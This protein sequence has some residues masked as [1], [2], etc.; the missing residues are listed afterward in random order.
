[1]EKKKVS[2]EKLL[3]SFDDKKK[4]KNKEKSKEKNKKPSFKRKEL[5]EDERKTIY[6][7]SRVLTKG[8]VDSLIFST[9][10]RSCFSSISYLD[11]FAD[12]MTR[13][14]VHRIIFEMNKHKQPGESDIFLCFSRRESSDADFKISRTRKGEEGDTHPINKTSGERI[15]MTFMGKDDSHVVSFEK[16]ETEDNLVLK[17]LPTSCFSV[18]NEKLIVRFQTPFGPKDIAPHYSFVKKMKKKEIFK[19]IPKE[20]F[21]QLVERRS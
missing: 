12:E 21:Q 2:L 18:S 13:S 14:L 7:A 5:T 4:K 20:I 15:V 9:N 16:V 10:I 1:M 3:K 11:Y 8:F 17:E 19:R 6:G